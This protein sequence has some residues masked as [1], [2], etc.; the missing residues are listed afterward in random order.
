MCMN[1]SSWKSQ[2]C[3]PVFNQLCLP[4]S[5][6]TWRASSTYLCLTLGPQA[7][8]GEPVLSTCARLCLAGQLYLPV[9]DPV[10]SNHTC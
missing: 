2:P 4:V 3:L 8:P 7:T 10:S 5:D 1:P 6:H 9:Y